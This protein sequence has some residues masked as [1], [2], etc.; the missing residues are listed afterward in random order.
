MKHLVPAV[1]SCLPGFSPVSLH[2]HHGVMSPELRD[3]CT[4]SLSGLMTSGII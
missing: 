3:L 1:F 4:G 2:A